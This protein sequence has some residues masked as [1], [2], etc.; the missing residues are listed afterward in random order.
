MTGST[1][2]AAFGYGDFTFSWGDHICAFF[3]DREQQMEIMVPFMAQ[4]IRA[5]QRC[6]WVGTEP[7]CRL[8]RESFVA[9]GADLQT[10]E[11]S[12]QLVILSEIEFYLKDGLFEP[13]RTLELGRRLRLDGQAHGYS[14]MRITTDMPADEHLGIDPETWELYEAQVTRVMVG[15]PTVAVCQYQRKHTPSAIVFAALRTHPFVILDGAVH[16]NP[17]VS[18]QPGAA[19]PPLI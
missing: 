13:S 18:E 7:S 2:A 8:F 1:E 4:G 6:V 14:T 10:L 16:E 11:V 17:F 3:D 9:A 15:T 12:G 5:H 19:A